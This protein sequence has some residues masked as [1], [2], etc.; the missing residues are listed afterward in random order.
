MQMNV[1]RS[2][3]PGHH[4]RAQG[5]DPML[6]VAG[7]RQRHDRATQRGEGRVSVS[8]GGTSLRTSMPNE[9]DPNPLGVSGPDQPEFAPA[10]RGDTRGDRTVP[11]T[12]IVVITK[13]IVR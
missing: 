9:H 6:Q 3:A 13:K 12:A 2:L 5:I 4:P 1:A 8:H 11:I 10:G 7:V